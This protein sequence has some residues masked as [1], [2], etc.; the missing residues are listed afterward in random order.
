ML[1]PS[2]F[3]NGY[4]AI[5]NIDAL[6][7]SVRVQAFIDFFTYECLNKF[8]G[9]DISER[10]AALETADKDAVLTEAQDMLK[11]YVFSKWMQG[12]K[13]LT[14]NGTVVISSV[15][16]SN[17]YD[18]E[19]VADCYNRAVNLAKPFEAYLL[20]RSDFADVECK[21]KKLLPFLNY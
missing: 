15:A 17:V 6:D 5:P 8:F 16:G 12:N 1:L 2:N 7:V 3:S 18:L 9:V 14:D 4:T 13:Q 21:A 19:R 10:I 11:Y 20:T